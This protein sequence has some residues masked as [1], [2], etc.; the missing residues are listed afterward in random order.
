MR[1]ISSGSAGG[2]L[3]YLDSLTRE[4]EDPWP[5]VLKSA[6]RQVFLIVD[7]D[8]FAALDVT[9]LDVDGYLQRF[10]D[11]ARAEKRYAPRSLSA[12]Q[13]RFRRAIDAYLS[14]LADPSWRPRP[15]EQRARTSMTR[16]SSK[17]G[18]RDRDTPIG[19][20][21]SQLDSPSDSAV[22]FV[23]YPFPLKSGE[24]ARLHLPPQL[25]VGDAERLM[26]FI[27]ALVVQGT[28]VRRE[29]KGD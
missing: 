20:T 3:A 27:Q 12:Y 13:S 9:T 26:A 21:R 5:S 4:T 29:D 15:L 14:H 11:V 6:A 17:E 22:P 25:D 7:G 8:D 1:N 16:G 18:L 19:S 23:T 2:L 28:P 24:I 10:E